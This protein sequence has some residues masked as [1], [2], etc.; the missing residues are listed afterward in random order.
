[1]TL[2]EI[3][4]KVHYE[5]AEARRNYKNNLIKFLEENNL[6]NKVIRTRDNKIGTLYIQFDWSLS[7]GNTVVFY[8]LKK[9]GTES[10]KYEIVWVEN[11]LKDF[12]PYED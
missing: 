12:K 2:E 5:V 11:I 9:D 10:K 3:Q 6:R 8:P 1:M 7:E 4:N